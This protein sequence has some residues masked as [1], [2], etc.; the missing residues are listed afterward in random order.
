[1]KVLNNQLTICE[2]TSPGWDRK[3][4]HIVLIAWHWVWS[5]TWRFAIYYSKPY[6]RH[7]LGNFWFRTQKSMRKVEE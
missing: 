7:P 5:L 3:S 4:H 2:P 1:M 6:E